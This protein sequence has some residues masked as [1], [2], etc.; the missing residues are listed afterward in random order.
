MTTPIPHDGLL[1]TFA[2]LDPERWEAIAARLMALPFGRLWIDYEGL[3]EDIDM[4]ERQLGDPLT[5]GFEVED[6]MECITTWDEL[7]QQRCLC[8]EILIQQ[9][10][11]DRTGPP[12]DSELPHCRV[13]GYRMGHWDREEHV[14]DECRADINR[15]I[16]D[17]WRRED[18]Y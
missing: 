13:C 18:R 8:E 3:L 2:N 17:E 16:Y 7:R 12:A 5:H 10:G 11:W 1:G 15:D 6:I 4:V 14:C 9:H